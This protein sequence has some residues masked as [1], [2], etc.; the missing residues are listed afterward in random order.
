[1]RIFFFN[2]TETNAS[3]STYRVYMFQILS[4]DCDTHF[5][6]DGK[7]KKI[8]AKLKVWKRKWCFCLTPL[9]KKYIRLER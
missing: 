8:K 1:M 6:A 7:T 5:Q 4:I 2:R 9:M 3:V